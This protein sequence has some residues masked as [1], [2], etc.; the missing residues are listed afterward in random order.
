M[1]EQFIQVQVSQVFRQKLKTLAKKN[2]N[3][4]KNIQ[5]FVNQLVRSRL[6]CHPNTPVTIAQLVEPLSRNR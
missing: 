3:V 4:Q 6:P 1:S 2:P 5:P